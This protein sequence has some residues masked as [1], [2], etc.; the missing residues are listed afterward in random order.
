[1]VSILSP[2]ALLLRHTLGS[3]ALDTIEASLLLEL[4]AIAVAVILVPV[5]VDLATPWADGDGPTFLDSLDG[6]E[7]AG[8]PSS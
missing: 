6:A 4:G 1:M 2:H 7:V 8:T 5:D 3:L